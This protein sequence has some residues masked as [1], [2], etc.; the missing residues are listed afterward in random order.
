MF[1]EARALYRQ[2]GAAFPE[3]LAAALATQ[4]E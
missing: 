2:A 4:L 3:T 1:D